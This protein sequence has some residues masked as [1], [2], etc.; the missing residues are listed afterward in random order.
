MI[1]SLFAAMFILGLTAAC[2]GVRPLPAPPEV[3]YQNA[4]VPGYPGVRIWGDEVTADMGA[5]LREIGQQITAR[6]RAEGAPPNGGVYD[7]LVLSGGGSDGAY[8]AGLLAGWTARGGRPEFG[9]VT[10]ISTGALIAP[11]A[12][13]G[14][15]YDGAL[16]QFYTNTG[17]DE[18]VE[19]ALFNA[20]FGRILGLTSP[21]HL[22]QIIEAE[23]TP[24]FIAKIAA[25]HAKG[26]RLW[27]GTT[28]LDSQ[29]PMLWDL[30]QHA[31]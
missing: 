27:V 20:L 31:A 17:T 24:D 1:R 26:R 16:E 15:D 9:L 7:I 14:S 25:E 29:P 5:R 22:S 10:G 2:T 30:G 3:D 4:D 28:N 21:S 8:G 19:F 18:V 12:F 13:L 6:I 11:Y 23:L